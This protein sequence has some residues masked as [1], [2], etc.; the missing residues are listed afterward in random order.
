MAGSDDCP[1]RAPSRIP[2][3]EHDWFP[4]SPGRP[5]D[6]RDLTLLRR[7]RLCRRRPVLLVLLFLASVAGSKTAVALA[8]PAATAMPPASNVEISAS[9]SAASAAILVGVT[10]SGV[11]PLPLLSPPPAP[12]PPP[13]PSLQ[14]RR[15]RKLVGDW[16]GAR[17]SSGEHTLPAGGPVCT[18]SAQIVISNGTALSLRTLGSADHPITSTESLAV[19]SGGSSSRL[20]LVNGGILKLQDLILQGGKQNAGSAIYAQAAAKVILVSTVVVKNCVATAFGGALLLRDAG[21]RLTSE[22][23]GTNVVIMDNVAASGGGGLAVTFGADILVNS[24]GLLEVRNN[25]A[26]SFY[27]GGLY[28][29]AS[30]RLTVSGTGSRILIQR[31]S[32]GQRGGGLFLKTRAGVFVDNGGLLTILQNVATQFGGGADFV[33]N[34]THPCGHRNLCARVGRGQYGRTDGWRFCRREWCQRV[35]P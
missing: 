12:P 35:N 21:T 26:T 28:L 23:A 4:V 29:D 9:V 19:I 8:V 1:R 14:G 10:A 6:S 3:G 24:G 11:L 30:A 32:A 5:C 27:G 31:N 20:F 16:C 25:T 18:L 7:R 17:L 15:R 2:P 34:G 22:G 33:S 13:P